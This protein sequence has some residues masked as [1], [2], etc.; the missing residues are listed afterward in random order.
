MQ[1][2]FYSDGID[3]YEQELA[4]LR[5]SL[6]QQ[7]IRQIHSYS[8]G[9]SIRREDFLRECFLPDQVFIF[10]G[11]KSLQG[12]PTTL[13]D[14]GMYACTYLDSFDD[15]IHS[16]KR[17]LTFC[18][19]NRYEVA[20]DYLCEVLTEFNVFDDQKRNMFLRLQVPIRF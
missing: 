1:N 15:E 3:S 4:T 11:G 16:A 19:E 20:G 10:A 7:N 12:L 6:I 5:Q 13:L 18:R 17:L 2:N 8:V 14:S 9:T